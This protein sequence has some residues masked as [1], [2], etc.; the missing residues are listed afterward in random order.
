MAREIKEDTDTKNLFKRGNIYWIQATHKGERIIQ[1]TGKTK[2]TDARE[3]RDRELERF[4]LDDKRQR[5]AVNNSIIGGIDGRLE[6]IKDA[7]PAMTILQAWEAFKAKPKG[8]TPRGRVIMPG[9]RTLADYEGRWNGFCTWMETNYAKKTAKGEKIP[10]ELRQIGKE[11]AEKY[12]AEIGAGRSA[13]T[14]N[15]TLTF[16]R[17]VFKVLSEDARI[18]ANPFDG[19]D[20]AAAAVSRKRPLTLPELAAIS[21]AL[22]GKGEMEILFS[23]GY[24]IGARLGDCVLMRW[25]SIDMASRKIRYTPSKTAKGNHEIALKI[26]PALFSLLDA[27]PKGNRR[28]LVLPELGELYRKDPSAVSKRVQAVFK[29]AKI[30]TGIDVKGYKKQVARVGFHSLRHAHI[31]ALLDGGVAMDMVRQQAGHST[32]GMTAH[33]YHASGKALQAATD[34]LPAM[35]PVKPLEK[36]AGASDAVL[37]GLG[38]ILDSMTLKQLKAHASKVQGLIGQLEKKEVAK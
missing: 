3:I 5:L 22:E 11:H 28:G 10:W 27:I 20:A 37:D 13:N 29:S 4:F 16:L 33:Y 1:S 24:Y 14:R 30:E 21:E 32:I 25:D 8:K 17:L 15:K 38:A 12:I 26:A 18:K 6:E 35:T 23:L 19:M 31:T 2:L 9:E 36:H 34:A 7:K